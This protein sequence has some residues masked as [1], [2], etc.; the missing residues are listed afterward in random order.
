[1]GLESDCILTLDGRTAAG[2]AHLDADRLTFR[3]EVRLTVMFA[4]I[5]SVEH[6]RR[7]L[8]LRR[9]DG[10]TITLALADA[11][12]AERWALKIRYPRDL[13]DKLGIKAGHRVTILGV[14]DD[15]F[16]AALAAR[17]DDVRRGRLRRDNDA[18][19]LAAPDA[20]RLARLDSL[21]PSLKR[22]GMIWVVWP[23]GQKHIREDDIRRRAIACGLVDIKVCSFSDTLSA[24][25]LVIPKARR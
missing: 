12:T 20:A 1:M 4:D 14:K 24:L 7:D 16:E 8:I 10:T 22:E 15:A 11:K 17:T 3:G 18:I 9:S 25:K 6:R 5:A 23:K 13:I 21:E 2:A 19:V